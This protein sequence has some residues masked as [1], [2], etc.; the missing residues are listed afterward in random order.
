MKLLNRNNLAVT[1][2]ASKEESR[3]TMRAILCTEQETVATDGHM[4]VRTSLPK[5]NAVNFPVVTGFQP[6][7]FTRALLP[8]DTAKEIEKAILKKT[9]FPIL[10]H[11]AIT[12]SA[13]NN[14]QVAVTDLATRK[15]FTV[16]PP[17][18]QFP[19]WDS[20]A[21]WDFSRPAN[22]KEPA[23]DGK[24]VIDITFDASL[25]KRMIDGAVK[26]SNRDAKAIRLRFY[27]NDNAMRFDLVNDDQQ[28][29]NGLVMPFRGDVKP[30]FKP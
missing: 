6:N 4:L 24:P 28:E 25:L 23:K 1:F 27:G 11:A 26:F 21:L 20:P 15:V 7:G 9:T 18:G 22:D 5:M 17:E 3:Y 30:K 12:T 8:V 14:L 13:D 16:K 19:K 29:M 2:A 10:Q